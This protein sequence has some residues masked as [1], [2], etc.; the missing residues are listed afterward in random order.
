VNTNP[1]YGCKLQISVTFFQLL[2]RMIMISFLSKWQSTFRSSFVNFHACNI[3]RLF[4]SKFIKFVD[5]IRGLEFHYPSE[6]V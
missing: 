6:L 3:M 4:F 2:T 1:R 5:E